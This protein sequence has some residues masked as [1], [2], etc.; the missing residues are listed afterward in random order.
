MAL[1]TVF[2][3]PGRDQHHIYVILDFLSFL[4]ILTMILTPGIRF[5]AA[6]FLPVALIASFAAF[7]Q[8]WGLLLNPKN[9]DASPWVVFLT[10]VATSVVY[11]ALRVVYIDRLHKEAAKAIG[12]RTMTRVKGKWP[13]NA[14]ILAAM[15]GTWADGYPSKTFYLFRTVDLSS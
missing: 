9:W 2:H 3:L 5:I 11:L 7:L 15:V 14:D 1:V 13:G 10:A 8:H 12:A 4:P 6:A